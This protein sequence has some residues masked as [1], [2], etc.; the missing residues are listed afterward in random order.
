MFE[1]L[2][3]N[4]LTPAWFK[5]VNSFSLLLLNVIFK[6]QS[7]GMYISQGILVKT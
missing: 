5:E 3:T 1:H 6:R 7:A 4:S 2:Q